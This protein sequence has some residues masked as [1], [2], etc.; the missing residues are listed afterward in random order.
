MV[1]SS[2]PE[3]A[4]EAETEVAV[5]IPVTVTPFGFACALTLPA[6]S[7]SEVE[8]TTAKVL[9]PLRN[10]VASLVPEVPR[11]SIETVPEERLEALRS[12]SNEAAVTIPDRFRCCLLRK[13]DPS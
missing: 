13:V 12:P 2:A 7:L 9:S 8:S 6:A 5:K 11:R 3:G 4:A 1:K 10:V